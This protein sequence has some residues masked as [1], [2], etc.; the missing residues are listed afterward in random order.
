V[1]ALLP[2]GEGFLEVVSP[3]VADASAQRWI[4]RR[5]GDAGY[6]LIF[7]CEAEAL[8]AEVARAEASAL[9]AEV[10]RAEAAGAR[11]VWSGE[12]EGGRTVHFHPRELGAIASLD[13]MPAWSDWVW[14]GPRE[15]GAGAGRPGEGIAGAR[16]VGPDPEALAA[17]WGALLGLAPQPGGEGPRIELPRGGWLHFEAGA[18]PALVGLEVAVTDPARF[19]A[20][21]EARGLLQG[22][23]SALVAGTRIAARPAP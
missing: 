3:V 4:E 16:L 9:D 7:Q 5:G 23:G 8:D 11:R 19:A 21:A 1:N 6:M 14:A 12:R 22:D 13:A 20:R 2:L 10:A 15:A 17:H 18:G